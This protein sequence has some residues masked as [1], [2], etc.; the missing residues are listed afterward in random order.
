MWHSLT[1]A[2]PSSCPWQVVAS[3]SQASVSA[4]GATPGAAV[5][6]GDG[7]AGGAELAAVL[8]PQPRSMMV[9][10]RSAFLMDG[11]LAR[12]GRRGLRPFRHVDPIG[13][14]LSGLRSNRDSALRV[15]VPTR[16]IGRGGVLAHL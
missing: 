7:V 15:L 13:R 4:D 9:A 3:S 11:L 5:S 14:E 12:A 16:G 2:L 1:S 10:L 8:P 6:A